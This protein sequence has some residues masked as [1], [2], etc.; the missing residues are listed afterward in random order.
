MKRFIGVLALLVLSGSIPKPALAAELRTRGFFENVFERRK[1]HGA[2]PIT[3][4]VAQ[5]L[6]LIGKTV[7]LVDRDPLEDFEAFL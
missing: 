1:G 4:A 2:R 3:L 6:D 5:R 7:F